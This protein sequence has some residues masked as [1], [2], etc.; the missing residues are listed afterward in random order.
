MWGVGTAQPHKHVVE[1]EWVSHKDASCIGTDAAN[2]N[3]TRPRGPRAR[4][5]QDQQHPHRRGGK[6]A[7]PTW[8]SKMVKAKAKG[9]PES[10]TAGGPGSHKY[11]GVVHAGTGH[12]KWVYVT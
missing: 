12:T 3:Q 11:R 9:G 7:V 2:L 5:L 4:L 1:E 6:G 8:R 10:G